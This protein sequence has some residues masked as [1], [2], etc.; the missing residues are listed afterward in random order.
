MWSGVLTV[1]IWMFLPCLAKS[2][3]K[4]VNFSALLNRAEF[5]LLSSVLRSTSQMAMTL[6]N[7]AA[8]SES[9]PPLPPQPMQATLNFSL[10]DWLS[11]RR[12]PAATKKPVPA[13][14]AVFRKV[15]RVVLGIVFTFQLLRMKR[16]P[17]QHT[18]IA[19]FDQ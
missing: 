17:H 14:E 2:S 6:P 15:R 1:A 3:R 18:A 5:P 13:R 11:A 19:R 7:S 4:S 9:L 12:V 8:L 16:T 10:G